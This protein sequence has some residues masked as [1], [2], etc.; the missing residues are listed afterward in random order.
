[1]D[2]KNAAVRRLRR[3]EKLDLGAKPDQGVGT[4]EIVL[5]TRATIW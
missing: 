5:E 4:V 2:K 1:M 3:S